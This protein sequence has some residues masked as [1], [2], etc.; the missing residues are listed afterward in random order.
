MDYVRTLSS[1]LNQKDRQRQ[2]FS[3]PQNPWP[4]KPATP[5]SSQE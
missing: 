2:V 3:L 4:L 1:V 5:R